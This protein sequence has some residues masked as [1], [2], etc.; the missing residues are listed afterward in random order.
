M[1]AARSILRNEF[2]RNNDNEKDM[3]LS[4]NII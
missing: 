1:V 4:I 2:V 3:S